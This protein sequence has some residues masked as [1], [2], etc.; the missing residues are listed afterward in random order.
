MQRAFCTKTSSVI[1]FHGC[2]DAHTKISAAIFVC[3]G[4]MNPDCLLAAVGEGGKRAGALDE[5]MQRRVGLGAL[6]V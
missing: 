2:F 4:V 1:P 3:C 5:G 6:Y